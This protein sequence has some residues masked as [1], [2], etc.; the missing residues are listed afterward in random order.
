LSKEHTRS[1]FDALARCQR[2]EL[3]SF[4]DAW[5]GMEPTF[6]NAKAVKKW[7]KM[8]AK[9]KTGEDAYFEDAWMRKKLHD[10]GRELKKRYKAGLKAGDPA[11]VFPDF[12]LEVDRDPWDVE[13]LNFRFKSGKKRDP[14]FEVRFGMDPETFEYSI[15]PVPLA[16]F[17]DD[18]F[19]RFLQKFVW[20]VPL[21]LGLVASMAHGGGQFSTSAKTWLVGSLLADDIATKLNHPELS[22]WITD[23]P[24]CDDRS[25]RATRRR[26]DAYRKIIAQ[27]WAGAFHPQ[28]L[29]GIRV[30]HA[31]LDYG[32]DP[33][34]NPPPGL[35]NPARGPMGDARTV[36][37]TNFVFGRALR[38]LAQ[39]VHPGYWQAQH[40]DEDGYRA[41]QIMRYSEGNLNRLRVAGELHVKSGKVLDVDE[42]PE[43][44]APLEL[45][46]LYDEASWENRGQMSRT[47]A[48]DFVEAVLLDTHYGAWLLEHPHVQVVDVLAQDALLA[49]AEQTLQK[50]APS[51][52]RG[53]REQARADNLAAS[54]GRIK[55]DFVEPETLFWATWQVLP[56]GQKA[57][58]AREAISGFVERVERAASKDPRG[59]WSDPM[60]PHRHRVQPILWAALLAEAGTLDKHPALRREA[61][62]WQA[63]Q[64]YYVGKRP[65]WSPTGAPTPWE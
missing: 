30:E 29:G 28:A 31:L 34:P 38:Y 47:S 14:V 49:D 37:E 12:E 7:A 64:K 25:F 44:D 4:A 2:N 9:G 19:V 22:T 36:F 51:T 40:P 46:M 18:D 13:R 53:L 26:L 10:V 55:S 17:H 11:C 58:I 60:E 23:Y 35:M 42:V 1:L 8:A 21:E 5:V 41:D 48:E 20:D 24:N 16:W 65:M 59:K 61:K 52:L 57:E 32:F 63:N 56:A 54:R 27:Y 33:A 62:Q 6:S 3:Q 39:G 45:A 43:F 50:L 15:K